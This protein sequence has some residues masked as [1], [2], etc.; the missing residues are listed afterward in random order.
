MNV[1]FCWNLSLPV[2]AAARVYL[3]P[4]AKSCLA[5]V[6]WGSVKAVAAY[7]FTSVL[8][9]AFQYGHFYLMQAG[10][11][12]GAHLLVAAVISVP[13]LGFL[14]FGIFYLISKLFLA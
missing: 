1:T 11:F 9:I 7:F 10:V 8:P 6:S 4:A 14:T 3:L 13:L 2:I 12:L 5:A